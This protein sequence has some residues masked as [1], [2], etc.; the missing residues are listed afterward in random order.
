MPALPWVQRE[1]VDPATSYQAMASYLPL[2][3][4]RSIPGFLTDALAIRRQLAEAEGLIGYA[5]DAKLTSK[6]FWTFS[7]WKTRADLDAFA[8]SDPHQKIIRRLRPRMGESRFAFFSLP[9]ET[10]PLDQEQMKAPLR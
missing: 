5:L 10:L 6:T 9:G 7:V 4:H 8:R 2:K 1:N 3:R